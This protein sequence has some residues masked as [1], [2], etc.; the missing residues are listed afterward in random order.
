MPAAFGGSKELAIEN[1]Q[2]AE[3]LMESSASE[4]KENWNYISLLLAIGKAHDETANYKMAKVYYEKILK[5]EP[6]FAWVKNELYPNIL[7]KV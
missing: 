1:Y 4:I 7:K 2:K 5:I 3:K 6:R